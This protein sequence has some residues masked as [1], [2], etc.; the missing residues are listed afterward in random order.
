MVPHYVVTELI[1][2]VSFSKGQK[3]DIEIA[4]DI[5]ST[6]YSDMEQ[7]INAITDA[8]EVKSYLKDWL[9][10]VKKLPENPYFEPYFK[11]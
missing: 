7:L 5:A 2:Q 10:I 6:E 1:G 11:N 4:E 3:N 9:K 8:I